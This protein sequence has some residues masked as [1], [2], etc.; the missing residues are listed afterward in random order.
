MPVPAGSTPQ[1]PALAALWQARA[2]TGADVKL[3]LAQVGG[4]DGDYPGDTGYAQLLHKLWNAGETFAIVE[5]DVQVHEAVLDE[6]DACAEPYC[7]FP[8]PL[9]EY[10]APALGCTRFRGEL[11]AELPDVMDRVLRVPTNW[12]PPG[13]WRQLDVVLMRT[14]LL[15]RYGLQPH[16]HMP[17]VEHLNPTMRLKPGAPARLEVPSWPALAEP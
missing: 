3:Y 12:G 5:H 1:M 8:Y 7:A 14:V 9:R 16:V 4:D 17:A 15:N 6:F 11:L 13:H 10:L 2:A